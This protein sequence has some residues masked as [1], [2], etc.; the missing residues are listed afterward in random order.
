MSRV[1]LDTI[2]LCLSLWPI[3]PRIWPDGSDSRAESVSEVMT[4]VNTF[5][6][7]PQDFRCFCNPSSPNSNPRPPGGKLSE[8]RAFLDHFNRAFSHHRGHHDASP[9]HP[10]HVPFETHASS[11]CLICA[12]PGAPSRTTTLQIDRIT[13][14]HIAHAMLTPLVPLIRQALANANRTRIFGSHAGSA[15]PIGRV[16]G[17]QPRDWRCE[18]R[19]RHARLHCKRNHQTNEHRFPHSA[20]LGSRMCSCI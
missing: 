5:P 12:Q 19:F 8:S 9:T 17:Q 18:R 13:I 11:F 15:V 14:R 10:R 20:A 1:V 2:P 3:C 16:T 4:S 6:R 7:T